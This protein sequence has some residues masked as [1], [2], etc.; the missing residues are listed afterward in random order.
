MATSKKIL[1]QNKQ[2]KQGFS[3]C[4]MQIPEGLWNI[5]FLKIICSINRMALYLGTPAL[6]HSVINVFM[7]LYRLLILLMSCSVIKNVFWGL[8]C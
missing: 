4:D 6:F 2:M 8:L 1:K 7:P 3:S 5:H